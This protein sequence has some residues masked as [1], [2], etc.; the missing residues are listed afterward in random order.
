MARAY[1]PD[2]WA[3]IDKHLG[4]CDKPETAHFAR[5]ASLHRARAAIAA[6]REPTE[7]MMYAGAYAASPI[8]EGV[9]YKEAAPIYTAM[10]DEALK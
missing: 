3:E 9:N 1:E 5:L 8:T 7:A 6:M 4:G 2:L 10:I